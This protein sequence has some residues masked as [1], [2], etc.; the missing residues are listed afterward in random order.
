MSEKGFV[1]IMMGD[2]AGKTTSAFGSALRF[3]AYRGGVLVLQFL[4]CNPSGECIAVQSVQGI[5]VLV[6]GKSSKFFPDMTENEKTTEQSAV[7][8][9]LQLAK[10]K[11]CAGTYGMIVLDEVGGAVENGFLSEDELLYF[12]QNKPEQMELILTGRHF[13]QVL[14]DQADYIS[15]IRC[16][17]HPYTQG[18]PARR[19]I[20]Y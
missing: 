19:G 20:E 11:M 14:L 8:N 13:S 18:V 16:V 4:K 3:S 15:E 12:L 6:T 17:K 1:H 2:G 9:A 5:D 7:K 10:E